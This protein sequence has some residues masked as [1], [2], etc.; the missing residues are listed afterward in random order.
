VNAIPV[1][2]SKDRIPTQIDHLS[3]EGVDQYPDPKLGVMVRYGIPPLVK[4]DAYL[5]DM[6]LSE[7]SEDLESP[8][9]I[10]LFQESLQTV[11]MAAEQGLYLDF[12]ILNSGYVRVPQDAAE[13]LCLCASFTYRLN[14]NA[15]LPKVG[16]PAKEGTGVI[17]DI[18]RLTS[19]LALRIDRGYINK[20][21]FN[22]PEELGERGFGGFLR[23]VMEWTNAVQT[24]GQ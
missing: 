6:G 19:H 21:R 8:Q 11:V 24:A 22:H 7:I 12:E 2:G 9:V 1:F 15:P 10:Q 17:N 3:L 14:S 4:V 23:F 20:V 13:P 16:I 5:Y 18:G